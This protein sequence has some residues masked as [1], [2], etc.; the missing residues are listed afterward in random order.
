M[1]LQIMSDLHRE[2]GKD[3]WFGPVE[4]NTVLVLAGDIELWAHEQDYIDWIY[5]FHELYK[6][7]III[8]GNHEYYHGGDVV[9]D[10]IEMRERFRKEFKNVF[11]IEKE[12]VIVDDVAFIGATLWTDLKNQ[13]MGVIWSAVANMNDFA[14]IKYDGEPFTP[15]NWFKEN[16]DARR[17]IKTALENTKQYKQVVVSHH[18]PSFMGIHPRFQGSDI[19]NHAYANTGLDNFI[20]ENAPDLWI[21]GHS[22]ESMDWVLGDV[23]RVVSNPRGYEGYELNENFNPQFTVDI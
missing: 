9:R 11:F 17:F 5:E 10:T 14:T 4:D 18:L 20:F 16:Q 8:A 1:K 22:H 7:V 15:D 12:C 2:F 19:L 6:A 3:F 21:H 13:D 23:T